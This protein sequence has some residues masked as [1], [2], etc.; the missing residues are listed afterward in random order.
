[1]PPNMPLHDEHTPAT[2]HCIS[3]ACHPMG[4][5]LYINV[6]QDQRCCRGDTSQYNSSWG[7][8]QGCNQASTKHGRELLKQNTAF[9]FTTCQNT[10][11]DVQPGQLMPRLGVHTCVHTQRVCPTGSAPCASLLTHRLTRA[12]KGASGR[13]CKH[14]RH[15]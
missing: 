1:M 6:S 5:L 4:P 14:S 12:Q 10:A 13:A 2:R 11:R 15:L 8:R 9:T 3:W 7:A